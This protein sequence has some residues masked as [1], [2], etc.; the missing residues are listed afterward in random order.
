MLEVQQN[1][2]EPPIFGAEVSGQFKIELLETVEEK[3]GTYFKLKIEGLTETPFNYRV[4]VNQAGG[5]SEAPD[6]ADVFR[7]LMELLKKFAC[8]ECLN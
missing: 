1:L 8:P 2:N 6:P 5:N 4:S 7:S 3:T